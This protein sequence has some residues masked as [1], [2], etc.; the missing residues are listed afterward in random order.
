MRKLFYARHFQAMPWDTAEEKAEFANQFV[1]FVE[2]DFSRQLFTGKFYQR[3]VCMFGFHAFPDS[4][5]VWKHYFDDEA[6]WR[7]FI[8][9]CIEHR[10]AGDAATTYADVH[11]RLQDWLRER[12]PTLTTN[13]QSH[14]TS[15]A[16]ADGTGAVVF[17]VPPSVV[18]M[19]GVEDASTDRET[20]GGTQRSF[21]W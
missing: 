8:L 4:Q 13:D 18:V 17:D 20:S 15:V 7:R 6:G 12:F 21:M 14:E 9:S 2:S 11:A 1:R 5:N 16:S 19:P 3:V 10:H